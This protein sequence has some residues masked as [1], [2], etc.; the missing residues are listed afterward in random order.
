[1]AQCSSLS[2]SICKASRPSRESTAPPGLVSAVNLLR[3]H[4]APAST[5]LIKMLNRALK[6]IVFLFVEVI[7]RIHTEILKVTNYL[8]LSSKPRTPIYVRKYTSLKSLCVANNYWWKSRYK[9]NFSRYKMYFQS[10]KSQVIGVEV[11]Y[12]CLMRITADV[13]E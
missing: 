12:F 3:M 1:M 2:G 4:S 9:M 7:R 10:I 11:T 6:K 13:R 5:S 8:I